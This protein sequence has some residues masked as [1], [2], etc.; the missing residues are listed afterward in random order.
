MKTDILLE[1]KTRNFGAQNFIARNLLS[2]MMALAIVACDREQVER[3]IAEELPPPSYGEEESNV[4]LWLETMEMGSRELYASR[5]AVLAACGI[6]EGDSV[7]D[8]G[9]GTGLYTVLFGNAVGNTGTVFAVDIEP[10]FLRLI[11]QRSADNDL[12]NVVSVLG[13]DNDITLPPNSIDV[14]YIAD[15]YHYFSEPPQIMASVQRALNK[16][17]RLIILDYEANPE[18]THLRFGKGP[19][20]SEIESFGFELVEEPKVEGL[21]DIYM[22]VFDVVKP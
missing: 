4:D 10:R 5:A 15:T 13:Q 19:L 14:A 11:N 7:A 16:G 9:A 6:S 17:G 3:D 21:N 1:A 20:I 2:G 8:I 18:R 22:V 12:S